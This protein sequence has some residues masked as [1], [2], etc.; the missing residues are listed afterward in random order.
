MDSCLRDPLIPS[1]LK[2]QFL[3]ETSRK[4]CNL[5]FQKG[6]FSTYDYIIT[7]TQIL[8]IIKNVLIK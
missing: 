6:P 7:N 5:Q 2:R 8:Y 1:D 3:N 4:I